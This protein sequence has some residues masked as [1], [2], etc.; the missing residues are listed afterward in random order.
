M[1]LRKSILIRSRITFLAIIIFAV[2]I[3]IQAFQLTV[4]QRDEFVKLSEVQSLRMKE[5][6]AIRG[7]ILSIDGRLLATSLPKYDILFDTRASGITEELFQNQ[8]DSLSIICA[9][10][11]PDKNYKQWKDYLLNARKKGNRYLLIRRDVS[12]EVA[13]EVSNW[14]IFRM[15]KYAGGLIKE[16]HN[17]RE[18]PFGKLARRTIGFTTREGRSVGLELAFDSLLR[19]VSGKRLEQRVS[20]SIW[21]PV[22]NTEFN[23][24]NGCDI[25]TTLDIN[26]QDV[27]EDAL[28]RALAGSNSQSG[29]AILMEVET[30]AV[31]AIANYTKVGENAYFEDMNLGISIAS[32]PGSTFKLASTMALLEEGAIKNLDDSV[33]INYGRRQ[34]YDRVMEDAHLSEFKKVTFRYVFEHSS[35]VGIAGLVEETFKQN[36]QH[37]IDYLSKLNL[38]RPLGIEIKEEGNIRIKNPKERDW[39]LTTLP[40]MAIGYESRITPLQTLAMYNAIANNGKMVKPYFVSEIKKTGK[41]LWKHKVEVI[42]ENVCTPETAKKLRELLE[43]VIENGTAK[44]LKN[45]DY[46]V[47]GKT[48]TAQILVGTRY[49]RGSH[50]ASFVGYFP[51]DNPKYTCIVIINAPRGGVY[52]GGL[53][54]GPVFKEI[55]DKVYATL[56]NI[57]PEIVAKDEVSLPLVK[58]GFR[59]DIKYVLN[60]LKISS[61]T[62]ESATGS[63]WVSTYRNPKSISLTPKNSNKNQMPDVRGMGLRDAIYLL[64]SMGLYVSVQGYGKVTYQSITPKSPIQTGNKVFIEL[65]P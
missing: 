18:M 30:G 59:E 63:E 65:K 36:P 44:N 29:C 46:K 1:S 45:L 23:P 22:G 39:N 11:F 32:D 34:F 43:G 14:P 35:N 24:E 60:E 15:G 21:R 27:A 26:I 42:S 3:I 61:H 10:Y 38:D 49:D 31:K 28:K 51:A 52:Y 41:S 62:N 9:V 4:V 54:A 64:E 57:H 5:V 48:G 19:G 55:A 17:E 53:V 33:T 25:V 13:K 50:K 47:A 40:W 8:V 20:G 7:N 56:L 37:Y 2:L 16:E 6:K 58:N 12:Y